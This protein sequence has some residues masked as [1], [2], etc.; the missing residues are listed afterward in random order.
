M[1]Y[2]KLVIDD[3]VYETVL[4]DK[5][6]NRSRY[7]PPA[8]DKIFAAIPGSINNIFVKKGDIIHRNDKLLIL[9]AMKMENSVKSHLE[10]KIKKIHVAVGDKVAKNQLLIE[11]EN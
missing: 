7:E 4:T 5:Y 11:F 6:K 8:T 10:G 1:E 3:T 2:N 9:E